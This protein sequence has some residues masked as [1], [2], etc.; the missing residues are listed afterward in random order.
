MHS[1]TS[2]HRSTLEETDI[3]NVQVVN[4]GDIYNNLSDI[5]TQTLENRFQDAN[6]DALR[7]ALEGNKAILSSLNDADVP[8]SDVVAVDVLNEGSSAVVYVDPN[9]LLQDS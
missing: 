8:T 9:D 6:T 2:T 4:V 3:K 5:Q 7:D 1:K